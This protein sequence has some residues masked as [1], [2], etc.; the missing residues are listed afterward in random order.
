MNKCY[1]K[2]KALLMRHLRLLQTEFKRN[3]LPVTCSDAEQFQFFCSKCT[4]T[5]YPNDRFP[6][7]F[8]QDTVSQPSYY[9]NPFT[10]NDGASTPSHQNRNATEIGMPYG[11]THPTVP[12]LLQ[13][14]AT[15]SY[16]LLTSV[17]RQTTA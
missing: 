17:F 4:E 1:G 10:M 6:T 9:L 3:I 8:P 13:T 16:K 15:N 2:H 12:M 11:S 5:S 7:R 14:S